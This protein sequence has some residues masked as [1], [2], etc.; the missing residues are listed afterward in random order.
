MTF[1][2]ST[3]LTKSEL[4]LILSPQSYTYASNHQS[5]VTDN[6]TGLTWFHFGKQ[7]KLSRSELL[8]GD[9]TCNIDLLGW[10]QLAIITYSLKLKRISYQAGT[11]NCCSSGLW[12]M[13]GLQAEANTSIYLPSGLGTPDFHFAS[14]LNAQVWHLSKSHWSIK[15]GWTRVWLSLK[16]EARVTAE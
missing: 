4:L 9:S 8:S 3:S 10:S 11:G 7:I 12:K 16:T 1:L 5:W 13:I 15:N 2:Q 6:I 14:A